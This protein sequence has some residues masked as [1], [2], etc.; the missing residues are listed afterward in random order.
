MH[1]ISHSSL[2]FWTFPF[3]STLIFFPFHAPLATPVLWFLVTERRCH[4]K[5]RFTV[6]LFS[7]PRYLLQTCQPA[8]NDK[9]I[10]KP[11]SLTECLIIILQSFA[12]E[13]KSSL[14][15]ASKSQT[16][17]FPETL[18]G[19]IHQPWWCTQIGIQNYTE[20]AVKCNYIK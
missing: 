11:C 7:Y 1:F 16:L 17:A 8:L 14:A 4:H 20:I 19:E 9:S 2:S 6:L 12:N 5:Q 10:F 13:T 3:I 18:M 15:T